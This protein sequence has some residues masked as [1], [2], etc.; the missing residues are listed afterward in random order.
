MSE[1]ASPKE[2]PI[3]YRG[4]YLQTD[5]GDF[6]VTVP[7]TVEVEKGG[8]IV[9]PRTAFK[10]GSLFLCSLSILAHRSEVGRFAATTTIAQAWTSQR[11][12]LLRNQN[13][14]ST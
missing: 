4:A 12:E 8:F 7:K 5:L 3:E 13:P 9:D 14:A 11:W 1:T 10:S 2:S 6:L